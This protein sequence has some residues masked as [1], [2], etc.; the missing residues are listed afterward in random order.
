[1]YTRGDLQC[2]QLLISFL[3]LVKN[4]QTKILWKVT[5]ATHG[6]L[7][8]DFKRLVVFEIGASTLANL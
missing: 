4:E 6:R 5:T 7:Q 2:H 1:M 3:M 8:F